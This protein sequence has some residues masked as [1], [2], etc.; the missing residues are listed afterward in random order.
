M[1]LAPILELICQDS[2]LN[3]SARD[4][5]GSGRRVCRETLQAPLVRES[6]SSLL[7]DTPAG[8]AKLREEALQK[9]LVRGLI[10]TVIDVPGASLVKRNA[11]AFK[12]LRGSVTSKVLSGLNA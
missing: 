10:L 5:C 11:V 6:A 7:T 12:T 4:L 1:L 9:A 3:D 2:K 8:R